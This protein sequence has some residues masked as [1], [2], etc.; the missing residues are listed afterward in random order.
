MTGDQS[1]RIHGDN[2]VECSRAFDYVVAALGD[3]VRSVDGPHTSLTCPAY[4]LRLASGTLTFQF[5]P[6][7]GDRRWN[8]DFLAFI[9]RSGG[10]LS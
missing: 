8:Q 4:A 6:G 5:L 3:A 10:R 2:I 7:Y 9:K 1:F